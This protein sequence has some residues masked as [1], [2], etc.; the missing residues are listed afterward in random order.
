MH[1]EQPNFHLLRVFLT[2]ANCGS[3]RAAQ[4]KLGCRASTIGIS[5]FQPPAEHMTPDPVLILACSAHRPYRCLKFGCLSTSEP[6]DCSAAMNFQSFN[7][8]GYDYT[9]IVTRATS[10]LVG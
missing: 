5:R 6:K 10:N 4:T 2:V 1:F 9:G 8:V 3:F 7:R